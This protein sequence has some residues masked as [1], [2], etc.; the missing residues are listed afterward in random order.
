MRTN[1][2]EISSLTI[3]DKFLMSYIITSCFPVVY[4]FGRFIDESDPVTQ[5]EAQKDIDSIFTKVSICWYMISLVYLAYKVLKTNKLLNQDV[6]QQKKE[7]GT[8]KAADLT[9]QSPK[10]LPEE[11]LV[12][13]V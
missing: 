10:D 4:M 7:D 2:P 5:L 11:K 9:W 13:A 12:G 1:L 6:P 3:G 8:K